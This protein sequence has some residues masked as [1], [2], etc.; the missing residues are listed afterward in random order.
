MVDNIVHSDTGFGI[1]FHLPVLAQVGQFQ[2]AHF[3]HA[4]SDRDSRLDLAHNMLV[5]AKLLYDLHAKADGIADPDK[6]LLVRAE[7]GAYAVFT[8]LID[9]YPD[10]ESFESTAGT[11]YSVNGVLFP[12]YKE[13]S[14]FAEIALYAMAVCGGLFKAKY[15]V[16]QHYTVK[17]EPAIDFTVIRNGL[18]RR[19]IFENTVQHGIALV[20]NRECWTHEEVFEFLIELGKQHCHDKVQMEWL[21]DATTVPKGQP[22]WLTD[23]KMEMRRRIVKEVKERGRKRTIKAHNHGYFDFEPGMDL[24]LYSRR[25]QSSGNK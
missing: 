22:W 17:L 19:H 1:L 12:N 8:G 21:D 16:S 24:K 15:S 3:F 13:G 4:I 10:Y 6:W 9:L 23:P 11:S 18:Y 25:E 2:V 20:N 14:M 7:R 5:L